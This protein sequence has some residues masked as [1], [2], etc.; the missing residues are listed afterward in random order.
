MFS[1]Q[2]RPLRTCLTGQLQPA[3]GSSSRH[4]WSPVSAL[5]VLE[6]LIAGWASL[7][8]RGSTRKVCSTKPR[9]NHRLYVSQEVDMVWFHIFCVYGPVSSPFHTLTSWTRAQS[10]VASKGLISSAYR[11]PT[12]AEKSSVQSRSLCLVSVVSLSFLVAQ[13]Q[14]RELHAASMCR[15]KYTDERTACQWWNCM[16]ETRSW[17]HANL[18]FVCSNDAGTWKRF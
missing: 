11:R 16:F 2:R 17:Q 6:Q 5:A 8:A 10:C 3:R 13:C 18:L 15:W 9:E 1:R 4:V 7:G 14:S 12:H